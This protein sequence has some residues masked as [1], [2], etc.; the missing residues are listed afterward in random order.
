MTD[1]EWA[2]RLVQ[3]FHAGLDAEDAL[4]ELAEECHNEGDHF[5]AIETT[6]T[7]LRLI[8]P[9]DCVRGLF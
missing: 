5:T 8:K 2:K 1:E 4:K 3:K 9:A 7:Y 6:K